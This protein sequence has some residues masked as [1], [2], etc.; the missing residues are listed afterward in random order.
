MKVEIRF[1]MRHTL[2]L[3]SLCLLLSFSATAQVITIPV[4]TESNALVLQADE[5]KDLS[6]T[7]FGKRLSNVQEYA[8]VSE[9][10]KQAE[11][12]TGV[13]DAAYTSSGSRNLAEPA[14][15][16]TH[17][18]GNTSLSLRYVSHKTEKIDSNIALL[19]VT[20]KDPAYPFQVVLYYKSYKKED[21]IEQWSVISHQ[22]KKEVILHKFASAN[23]HLKGSNDYWL[24]QF[25]GD[26][27]KEM[28]TEESRLTHGIKTLDSKLGTRTNLFQPPVFM[29]SLDK[30]ATEDEG[31][32]LYGSMEWSGNFRIDLELDPQDNLRII[33]GMNNFASDYSLKPKEEFKTPIFLYLL[34]HNGKARRAERCTLGPGT[35]SYL[36]ATVPG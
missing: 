31:T 30:P 36:T 14:I 26:W 28:Q 1:K 23:L 33:A 15:A 21:V 6:I 29:V 17:A 3:L 13:L 5:N 2:Y 10:Y 20:L 27:A 18:D 4:E 12:Y 8:K 11:D 34:S 19:S 32:V 9:V 7:Y 35:I 24:T 16:V 25:Y 22:E